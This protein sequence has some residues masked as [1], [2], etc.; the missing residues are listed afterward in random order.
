MSQE[1][2]NNQ[3]EGTTGYQDPLE[4]TAEKEDGKGYRDPLENQD[5]K[6]VKKKVSKSTIWAGVGSI[7]LVRFFGLLGALICYGGFCAVRAIVT[8][9][10][11]F[12]PLRVIL[13]I[14]VALLFVVL[15]LAE[16]TW[17]ASIR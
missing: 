5:G 15:L 2:I 11:M 14:V 8:N 7:V 9:K 4:R 16:I 10:K 12:L 1:K 13:G 17:A 3:N 6:E